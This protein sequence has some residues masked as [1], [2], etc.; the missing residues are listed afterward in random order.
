MA[1]RGMA[2]AGSV[3]PVSQATVNSLRSAIRPPFP[4]RER[5]R[6]P[7]LHW[8]PCARHSLHVLA[9]KNRR[10]A[11]PL[12]P[13]QLRPLSH[14]VHA[15]FERAGSPIVERPASPGRAGSQIHAAAPMS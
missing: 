7:V 9:R 10:R 12:V 4:H 14:F 11:T 15:V 6:G 3:R 8:S 1:R 5:R 13:A 2:D